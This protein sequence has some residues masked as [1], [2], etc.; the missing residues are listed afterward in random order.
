MIYV[1]VGDSIQY[2]SKGEPTLF[3]EVSWIG[4]Y[5]ECQAKLRYE[6][7]DMRIISEHDHI[8]DYGSK[9]YFVNARDKYGDVYTF[10]IH[11]ISE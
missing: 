7:G 9:Y 6:L 5:E 4:T 2:T 1:L 8:S 3:P 10:V 11:G